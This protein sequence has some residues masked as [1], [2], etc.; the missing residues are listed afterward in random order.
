MVMVGWGGG[1]E[2]VVVVKMPPGQP[3]DKARK[4][5]VSTAAY[6]ALVLGENASNIQLLSHKN[7]E[8]LIARSHKPLNH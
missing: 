1:G 7:S 6:S 8:S 4:T 2:Q 5:Q 3:A